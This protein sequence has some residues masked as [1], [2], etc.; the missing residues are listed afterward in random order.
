MTDADD[1]RVRFDFEIDF[2]NGGGIQG[3]DFRLDIDGEDI[4]DD[5][6]AAY[7]V[8]DLRLLEVAEVRILKKRIIR[9]RHKRA[10]SN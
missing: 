5:A 8:R 3:Q 10:P 9:E 1:H 4:D 6:L 2:A 7:I